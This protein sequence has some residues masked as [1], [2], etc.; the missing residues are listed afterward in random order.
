MYQIPTKLSFF[1]LTG[2]IANGTADPEI[3]SMTWSYFMNGK[4]GHY[5]KPEPH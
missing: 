4:L 5:L 2:N 1:P 3:D